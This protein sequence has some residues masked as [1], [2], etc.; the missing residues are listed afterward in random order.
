MGTPQRRR[1]LHPDIG[2]IL[3]SARLVG[4]GLVA[5]GLAA[6]GGGR[7]DDG[8]RTAEVLSPVAAL[9]E[10]IFRDPTLSASGKMS[11]A[12]CHEPAT[13]HSTNDPD[14]VVPAGGGALAT[15][16]FRNSP[17]L[18][19]LNL[20]P[21]FHFAKDGTPTGGLTRDGKVN[22][23]RE[24]VATP[25]VAAHEM[26]NGTAASVVAKLRAASY[27]E[28]FRRV[29]GTA[30]F[31]DVDA[32]FDRARFA[33]GQYQLEDVEFHSFDGKYDLFLAGRAS[34]SPRTAACASSTICRRNTTA[35]ST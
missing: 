31:D 1:L 14:S 4:L 5:A 26:A 15:P 3:R 28:E 10:E 11:C 18:R 29:F 9:G 20:T 12:T 22:T 19:Y 21:A 8:K 13:G 2:A 24:Q 17:S 30:I 35:T 33:L 16:G 7:G 27:A 23:L 25:L 32:A 6:C 34:L